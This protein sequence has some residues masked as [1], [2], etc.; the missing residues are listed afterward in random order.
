[1]VRTSNDGIYRI[2]T[3][4]YGLEISDRWVSVIMAGEEVAKLN[5]ASALPVTA[6][7]TETTP[8][9]DDWD[10][11]KLTETAEADGSYTYIYTAKSS[12]WEKKEYIF[13]CFETR[14]EYSIRVTGKGAVDSVN[15]FSGDISRDYGYGST[16]EFQ[17]YYT[18]VVSMT[19]QEPHYRTAMSD[20]NDFSYLT[21]PPMFVYT[22]RTEGIDGRLVMALVAEKGEH[23]FTKFQYKT[24]SYANLRHFYLITDQSGHAVVDG[25]WETPRIIVYT[26]ENDK[27]A[28]KAYSD[29]YYE[30]GIAKKRP[31]NQE[32]PRWWY[33][34]MACGWIEQY[35]Y[36]AKYGVNRSCVDMAYEPLYNNFLEEL[37]RRRLYPKIMILDDK[38]QTNYGSCEVNTEKWPDLRGWID[39]Q[40]KERG[41]KTMLWFKMWDS[42]GLDPDMCVTDDEGKT[43]VDPTNPKYRAKLKEIIH[44]LISADE[45]CCNAYGFKLD[46]AFIQPL[47]R[48][49]KSYSGKYGV[50]LFHELIEL[51]YECVKAE[52]ADAIVNC[53]PCH[54]YFGAYVDHARLHDYYPDNRNC[55]EEFRYRKELYE[56][57]A[58]G[59]LFDTDGAAFTSKR[60]TMRYMRL[61]PTLGI[62]DL[63]CITPMP[64]LELTDEDWAVASDAWAEYA[65]RIDKMFE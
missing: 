51:I 65:K 6:E 19:G 10:S 18:P 62:P 15:Y 55:F 30:T 1:M 64:S 2:Q 56:I 49:V 14:F 13:K 17:E 22:F 42:E 23:N 39:K 25:T 26:S 36:A 61:A 53:S 20:F 44:N 12:I 3:A 41:V 9:V 32:R 43:F 4:V 38:W 45:G 58:P 54:P 7:G 28:L 29:Y 47:G 5:P 48:N 46:Y 52:K 31:V 63:Y 8:D 59:T 57:A 37:D 11:F 24:G 50:E 27:T 34:P 60:D 35:A 40:D 21:V 33:G 16:Y